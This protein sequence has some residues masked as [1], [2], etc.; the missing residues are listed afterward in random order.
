[1]TRL[2]ILIASLIFVGGAI[3]YF[4]FYLKSKS[5]TVPSAAVIENPVLNT[6]AIKLP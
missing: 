5:I 2:A 4:F 6:P 1:M 3:Y